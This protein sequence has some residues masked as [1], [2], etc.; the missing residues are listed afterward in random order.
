MVEIHLQLGDSIESIEADLQQYAADTE[1]EL[2]KTGEGYKLLPDYIYRVHGIDIYV[3]ELGWTLAREEVD[4]TSWEDYLFVKLAHDLAAKYNG[5]LYF[6]ES[7]A[8]ITV[9]P[10]KFET[11]DH[12]VET[13]LERETGLFKE[14]KKHWLYAHK[15]RNVH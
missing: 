3:S 8:E 5:N 2:Q 7:K 10:H 4:A 12:Y 13:V 14:S 9:T 6:G 15:K 11:F 1:C